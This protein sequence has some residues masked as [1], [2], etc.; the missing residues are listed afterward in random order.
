MFALLAPLPP[1][2]SASAITLFTF[3]RTFAQVRVPSILVDAVE[4]SL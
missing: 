1:T 3:T 2:R 4:Q